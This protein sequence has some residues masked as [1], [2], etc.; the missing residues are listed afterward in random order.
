MTPG[1]WNGATEGRPN[2]IN[3]ERGCQGARPPRPR[4]SQFRTLSRGLPKFGGRYRARYRARYQAQRE[5]RALGGVRFSRSP[6]R[7]PLTNPSQLKSFRRRWAK[8]SNETDAE[9]SSERYRRSRR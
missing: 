1:R 4:R 5:G 8:R 6:Q 3:R 7:G 9:S 2:W